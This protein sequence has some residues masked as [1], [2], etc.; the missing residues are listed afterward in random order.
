ML[1][2]PRYVKADVLVTVVEVEMAAVM[3]IQGCDRHDGKIGELVGKQTLTVAQIDIEPVD[4]ATWT[5]SHLED[6]ELL[7]RWIVFEPVGP[8][9]GEAGLMTG[10][11]IRITFALVE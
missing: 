7:K 1:Q 9:R 2:H 4:G 8:K 10:T 5:L 3:S 6:V 11:V